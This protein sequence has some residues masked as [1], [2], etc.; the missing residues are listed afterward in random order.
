MISSLRSFQNNVHMNTYIFNTGM[1][2]LILALDHHVLCGDIEPQR[3]VGAGGARSQRI[4]QQRYTVQLLLF[5][6]SYYLL[7]Y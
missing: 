5:T 2:C 4:V 7:V 1:G 3:K 6:S